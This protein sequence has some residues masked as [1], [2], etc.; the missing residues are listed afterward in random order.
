MRKNITKVQVRIA[1]DELARQYARD[2]YELL[3]Q[4]VREDPCAPGDV[5]ALA[6]KLLTDAIYR[7][8]RV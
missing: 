5:R 2:M 4:F 6:A 8:A 7:G 3:V 1:E